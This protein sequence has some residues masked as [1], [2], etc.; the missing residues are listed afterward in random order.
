MPC[1][2]CLALQEYMRVVTLYFTA[3]DRSCPLCTTFDGLLARGLETPQPEIKPARAP[4]DP[5][6]Y[7]ANKVPHGRF[8]L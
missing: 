8:P 1:I 2:G 3:Y 7:I 5:I 4:D 6:V